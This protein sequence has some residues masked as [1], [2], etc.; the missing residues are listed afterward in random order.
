MYD[1]EEPQNNISCT[2]FNYY[3]KRAIFSI[4]IFNCYSLTTSQLMLITHVKELCKKKI[5]FNDSYNKKLSNDKIWPKKC[6]V[7]AIWSYDFMSPIKLVIITSLHSHWLLELIPQI[8]FGDVFV[9]IYI[10]TWMKCFHYW[11]L[12]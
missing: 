7:I 2:P 9:M 1:A 11:Y 6:F 3:I 4:W 10:N 12:T 8:I 5:F